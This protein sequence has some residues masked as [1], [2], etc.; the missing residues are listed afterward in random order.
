[1]SVDLKTVDFNCWSPECQGKASEIAAFI[2]EEVKRREARPTQSDA[3]PSGSGLTLK[4]Y[5]DALCLDVVFLFRHFGLR[6]GKPPYYKLHNAVAMPYFDEHGEEVATKWRWGMHGRDR[7]FEKGNKAYVYAGRFLQYFE[8][9]A[10]ADPL[11]TLFICEGESD[12]QTMNYLGFPTLGISGGAWQK[13]Y[14]QLKCLQ[15]AQIIYVLQD[16]PVR[17]NDISG[18]MF[19]KKV[20]AD[21]EPGKVRAVKLPFKDASE[22]WKESAKNSQTWLEEDTWKQA[23]R[24]A[25]ERVLR[26]AVQ[27]STEVILSREETNL[28]WPEPMREEAFYGVAGEFVNLVDPETEADRHALLANFL[29]AVGPLFGR[30]AWA[31]VGATRH[32]PFDYVILVG[33][34]ARSRKGTTTSLVLSVTEKAEEGFEK[35]RVLSGLST[36]EGLIAAI[37]PRED[38]PNDQKG[39]LVRLSELY[40]MFAVMKREGNTLSSVVRQAWDGEPL[41][42]LTRK[43]PLRADNVSL[44]VI[45]HI[46]QQELLNGL[47]D[48]DRANGFA[49]RF[50]FVCT[51]RSKLLPGGGKQVQTNEIVSKLHTAVEAAKGVGH[52]QRDE[53]AEVLWAH[54]YGRLTSGG[55]SLKDAICS[56]AEAHVLRLSLL[57]ALLDCSSKIRVEHLQAAIAFWDYCEQSVTYLFAGQRGDPEADKILDVLH[58]GPLTTS[59]IQRDAFQGNRN[60]EWVEAEVTALESAGHIRRYTKDY[61]VKKGIEAWALV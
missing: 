3:P 31:A 56:R 41:Y 23:A 57:Y 7:A 61:S 28:E 1:L 22:L 36:G 45:A 8:M 19:V 25:F 60:K 14:A 2:W 32:Y 49:N 10:E 4:E 42:V 37:Q 15:N 52:V 13:E 27:G 5:A 48:A 12:T 59:E 51:N 21:F 40:R 29:V 50:M 24:S 47:T 34:T 53:D 43:D 55:D 58:D 11:D 38:R 35:T 26:S 39:Y 44:S 33:K 18:L 17:S 54:E 20:A 6:E 16:L 9:R 46:T 30:E